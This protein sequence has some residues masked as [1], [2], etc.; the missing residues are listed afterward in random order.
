MS[1]WKNKGQELFPDHPDL[2]EKKHVTA[3]EVWNGLRQ[4]CFNA[5]DR[6]DADK[7]R[8]VFEYAKHFIGSDSVRLRRAIQA[9]FLQH[10]VMQPKVRRD[11]PNQLNKNEISAAFDALTWQLSEEEAE[12]FRR[13]MKNAAPGPLAS[14]V[15][16]N[17]DYSL[18]QQLG[19]EFHGLVRTSILVITLSLLVFMLFSFRKSQLLPVSNI[20]STVLVIS[21]I[22]A[23]LPMRDTFRG[24]FWHTNLRWTSI[25]G[26]LL[27]LTAVAGVVLILVRGIAGPSRQIILGLV[28][29]QYTASVMVLFAHYT[30]LQLLR[31]IAAS[32]VMFIR[33]DLWPGVSYVLVRAL[34]AAVLTWILYRLTHY[35]S[36]PVNFATI[37]C[38]FLAL[39][40][41][42]IEGRGRRSIP[43]E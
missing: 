10:L 8:R 2:F 16:Y 26:M 28:A 9:T 4:I 5:Y 7:I 38:T 41:M 17:K 34:P 30:S 22:F 31:R 15:A 25:V 42:L 29:A 36:N 37:F 21:S 23:W 3:T 39:I 43:K 18:F 27:I 14:A 40:L 13:E 11:L 19:D 6:G 12:Q 24:L 33:M 1:A 32:D 20:A 35:D